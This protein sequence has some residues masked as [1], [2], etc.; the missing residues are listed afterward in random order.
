MTSPGVRVV[1]VVSIWTEADSVV[2][3]LRTV[4]S[5]A[6]VEVCASTLVT[7][8]MAGNALSVVW[9][10]VESV[11]VAL[12]GTCIHCGSGSLAGVTVVCV[13]SKAS[14]TS[15]ITCSAVTI[16]IHVESSVADTTTILT[17][18]VCFASS[19]LVRVWS[20]ASRAAVVASLASSVGVSP[21]SVVTS[22]DTSVQGAVVRTA[23]ALT[24]TWTGTAVTGVVTRLTVVAACVVEVVSV[25][26]ASVSSEDQV[27]GA[28]VALVGVWSTACGATHVARLAEACA[29]HVGSSWA[30]AVVSCSDGSPLAA[31]A[32]SSR[33]RTCSTSEVTLLAESVRIH[34]VTVG[35]NTLV[36]CGQSNV[37][38]FASLAV[39]V[40][41]TTA[42]GAT[43]VARVTSSCSQ[44]HVESSLA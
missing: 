22:T 29:V 11:V 30:V 41:R 19:T 6:L 40:V 21:V 35:T 9:I 33:C 25:A 20:V 10:Q 42:C 4:A 1:V 32:I 15:W 38:A 2:Q 34:E 39:V 43:H 26:A 16:S 5:C 28:T 13:G 27:V 36:A 14:A 7:A 44:V 18:S 3:G 12:A 31:C 17:K 24:A 23:V 8:L 37:G